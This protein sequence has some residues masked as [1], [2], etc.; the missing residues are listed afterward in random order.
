MMGSIGA[1]LYDWSSFIF[2]ITGLISVLTYLVPFVL[3]T[4]VFKVQNFRTKYN[5]KWALVTG[6]SSGIGRAISERLASQGLNVIIVA[7]DDDL[8][9]QVTDLLSKQYPEQEFRKVGVNMASP[10]FM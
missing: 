2:W 3:Q 10:D 1:F 4:Y 5:A 6:G 8:L 7:L 9:L